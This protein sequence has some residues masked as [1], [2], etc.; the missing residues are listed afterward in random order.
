MSKSAAGRWA[1]PGP[2]ATACLGSGWLS[3]CLIIVHK[4]VIQYSFQLVIN[5]FFQVCVISDLPDFS[6][7]FPVPALLIFSPV[8]LRGRDGGWKCAARGARAPQQPC[9]LSLGDL[10]RNLCWVSAFHC[11]AWPCCHPCATPVTFHLFGQT[12]T[13]LHFKGEFFVDGAVK[14]VVFT[15][16]SYWQ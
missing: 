5:K 11:R 3:D 9:T 15:L 13:S 8:L 1:L 12:H 4:N 7:S 16:A 14:N 10:V 6:L 2:D